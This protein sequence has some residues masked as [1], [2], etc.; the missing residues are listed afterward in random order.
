VILLGVNNQKQKTMN[1]TEI[2]QAVTEIEQLHEAIDGKQSLASAIKAG[3]LL[4]TIKDTL[5]HGNF[6]KW[7]RDNFENVSYPT[8]NRYMRVA[9][10]EELIK[11]CETLTGA[12][13]LIAEFRAKEEKQPE[14][15]EAKGGESTNATEEITPTESEENARVIFNQQIQGELYKHQVNWD[16]AT[17]AVDNDR[18]N[19]RDDIN[20][21]QRTIKGLRNIVAH[22]C[23]SSLT[24]SEET[25]MKTEIMLEAL[26]NVIINETNK[27]EAEQQMAA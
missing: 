11:D 20:R 13:D 6:K 19:S 27:V 2:Q 3:Q 8:V 10:H 15:E 21:L 12:C 25:E 17:W 4:L 26:L 18:P 14:P 22:R 24:P 9:E 23:Y 1:E 16:V 7:V 5:A